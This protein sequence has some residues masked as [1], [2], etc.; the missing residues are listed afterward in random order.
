MA[1]PSI[2]SSSM[3]ALEDLCLF[4]L[5]LLDL[6]GVALDVEGSST[7][8]SP[9]LP[10]N[11]WLYFPCWTWLPR[12]FTWRC[13]FPELEFASLSIVNSPHISNEP[14]WNYPRRVLQGSY[15]IQTYS[16]LVKDPH[17][18]GKFRL[19]RSWTMWIS[20]SAPRMAENTIWPQ[21]ALRP[22]RLSFRRTWIHPIHTALTCNVNSPS[23]YLLPNGAILINCY[24]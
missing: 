14:A 12:R 24:Q 1:K 5:L 9:P 6:G 13:R 11:T 17:K 18:R 8:S 23:K 7:P 16:N 2:I 21:H 3:E 19:T 15:Y 10:S 4:L 22:Q 20:L